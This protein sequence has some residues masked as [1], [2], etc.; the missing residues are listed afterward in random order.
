MP[1][2]GK[3]A[4]SLNM[5]ST[6]WV[7][8]SPLSVL[9]RSDHV[10]AS[11]RSGTSTSARITSSGGRP[12]PTVIVSVRQIAKP[13]KLLPL[14]S[15]GSSSYSTTFC[16]TAAACWVSGSSITRCRGFLGTA[17]GC[18]RA[19][20]ISLRLR[21]RGNSSFCCASL[22]CCLSG[23]GSLLLRSISV[24]LGRIVTVRI[25]LDSRAA[26]RGS[27][28]VS[29][30]GPGAAPGYVNGPHPCRSGDGSRRGRGIWLPLATS[31]CS[32][33]RRPR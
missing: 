31:A 13:T 11:L 29:A 23:A 20:R 18:C 28:G 26:G 33:S 6:V 24:P 15:A 19:K 14:G 21:G 2:A 25:V 32:R 17:A 10:M 7:A 16:A 30:A 12:S 22:S 8:G 9:R 27:G 3:S 1:P 5:I 4:G